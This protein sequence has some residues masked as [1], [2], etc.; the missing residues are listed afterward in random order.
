MVILFLLASSSKNVCLK[1]YHLIDHDADDIQVHPIIFPELHTFEFHIGEWE[2]IGP[3]IHHHLPLIKSAPNL[4]TIHITV[5][6]ETKESDL[7]F[8]RNSSGWKEVDLQLCR[9][10]EVARGTVTLI[11]DV[12]L[13]RELSI[14]R[15]V[16]GALAGSEFLSKFLKA[17]GLVRFE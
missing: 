13:S 4:S 9:L 1:L 8:I 6:E 10:A 5:T 16:F 15:D 14:R 2:D 7:S 17:G 12:V 11:L 3:M